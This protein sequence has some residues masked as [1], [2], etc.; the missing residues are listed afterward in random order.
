MSLPTVVLY[1]EQDVTRFLDERPPAGSVIAVTPAAYSMLQNLDHP[2]IRSRDVFGDR[3]QAWVVARM[4]RVTRFF[5]EQNEISKTVGSVGMA[6]FRRYIHARGGFILASWVLIGRQG[7]WLIPSAEQG[8]IYEE[9]REAAHR[10]LVAHIWQ[11]TVASRIYTSKAAFPG[12]TLTLSKLAARFIGQKPTLALTAMRGGMGRF[13]IRFTKRTSYN[14]FALRA[15]FGD[16]RDPVFAAMSALKALMGRTGL[17]L[18]V[19]IGE[20]PQPVSESLHDVWNHID[21]P[22]L[23]NGLDEIVHSIIHEASCCAAMKEPAACILAAANAKVL[24]ADSARWGIDAA[25]CDA[26]GTLGIYRILGS[27]GSH[28]LQETKTGEVEHQELADG[29][30][31]SESVDATLVQ[32]PI[33]KTYLDYHEAK[34]ERINI[35]PI[36]WGVPEQTDKRK[37][38]SQI[39][40]IIHAGSLRSFSVGR[41]WVYESA[42]EFADGIVRLAKCV[43]DMEN[44]ELI[45]RMREI[46][47]CSE[48][49]L[50]SIMPEASNVRFE[51]SGQFPDELLKADLLVSYASTTIEEALSLRRPVLLWGGS[52]RYKHLPASTEPPT[53]HNRNAIYCAQDEEQL[54]EMIMSIRAHHFGVPLNDE[55]VKPYIWPDDVDGEEQFIEMVQARLSKSGQT[56]PSSVTRQ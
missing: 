16:W 53:E 29:M 27:H 44:T 5:I 55:E 54:G 40:R 12:I 21:D 8:W 10:A 13:G 50:R 33:V 48:A 49:V 35:K 47:E 2:V 18:L 9:S 37:P 32:S 6:A 19:P 39:F 1:C 28:P 52:N 7:P 22:I 4:R 26:A 3:Q 45:I 46:P 14:V 30:L 20:L 51:S 31:I 34:I 38:D 41:P 15:P 17:E 23:K 11:S 43:A 25:A 24:L 56:N 42:D 36:M